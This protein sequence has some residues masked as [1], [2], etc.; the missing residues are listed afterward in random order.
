MRNHEVSHG[1]DLD[2]LNAWGLSV[3]GLALLAG[4]LGFPVA[5]WAEDAV[6][7]SAAVN[8]RD[9]PQ[10]GGSRNIIWVIAQL[11]LLLAGFVLG[12]PIFA[13]LCEIV[14]WKTGEKRYDKLAKEFTKLLTSSY[15]T[16]ALFGGILLFLLIG[17][18]PKL[19]TYLTDIF[20]PSFV[21]YCGLFLLETATLYLYWY[22]WDAMQEGR[23]K[24][25]HLFLGF[26]LNVFAF[27]IM[28]IPNSWATFQA[29]P[30]VIAEGSSVARAWAATW[31]PT[32]WPV[33]IHRLI[34]NVVLGGY[35]CGA[36]AGVRYLSAK[37]AEEREHYD[38]MATSETL[39]VYS[40]CC[41]CP[42]PGTG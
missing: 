21:A 4:L 36:Y 32:W 30:V 7:A 13:W 28:V 2:R 42:S 35:I 38:W 11:H 26:L 20:F 15:A 5:G 18:Y 27:F 10:L 3:A 1:R 17:L 9:I 12:V 23:G 8:Y 37:S 14:G 29:S 31:N 24:V 34:A 19:M 40:A 6:S 22:G 25:F 39:S 33:N 41:R 16:T